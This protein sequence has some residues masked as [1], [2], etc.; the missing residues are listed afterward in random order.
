MTSDDHETLLAREKPAYDGAEPSGNSV[1]LMNLV[2][3][4]ELTT[5]D[6]YRVAA[7]K[8]LRGFGA[9]LRRSPGA[10][11]EMLLGLDFWLDTPKEIVIVTPG[12]RGQADPFVNVLRRSFLPN[13]VVVITSEKGAEN[14]A[15]AQL[16]PLIK[17]KVARKGRTTAYVCERG[18]CQLPTTDVDVFSRQLER[19]S[20]EEAAAGQSE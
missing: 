14:E 12:G 9:S 5:D 10:L 4:H 13:K 3:L 2:R 7:E 15:H 1:A 16:V 17:G 20:T 11:S 18:V 6:R 19:S 8:L